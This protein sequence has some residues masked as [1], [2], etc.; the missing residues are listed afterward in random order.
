MSFEVV[1]KDTFTLVTVR[2]EKLNSL[3]AP[4]LKSELV[5][6]SGKGEKNIVLDLSQCKYCDSSGLR[7]ILVANR[8]CDEAIGALIIS[9]LQ[10]EVENI[11]RISMLDSVLLI[12]RTVEEA[13]GLLLK[14]ENLKAF[15][16]DDDV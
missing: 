6:L 14:K 7:A 3:N 10:P 11:F 2:S 15:S 1:R 5:V 8:L 12:T 9:G 16:K 13:E 4:L